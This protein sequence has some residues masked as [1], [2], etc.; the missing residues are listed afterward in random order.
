MGPG[1]LLLNLGNVCYRT[2]NDPLGVINDNPELQHFLLHLEALG[3]SLNTLR[4][5]EEGWGNNDVPVT[6][7]TR[8]HLL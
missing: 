8:Q 3:L 4:D 5:E 2:R 7:S 6:V 1:L